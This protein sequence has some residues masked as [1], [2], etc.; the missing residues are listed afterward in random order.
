MASP[1]YRPQC[2][3]LMWFLVEKKDD[4]AVAFLLQT[5]ATTAVVYGDDDGN[6]DG[7]GDDL[8]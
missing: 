2:V 6:F 8:H 1:W 3:Y 5:A 7:C 4:Y